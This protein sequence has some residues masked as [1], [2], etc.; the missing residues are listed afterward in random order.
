M[1]SDR[2]KWVH[3]SMK[4][5][6]YS[7][8]LNA[9]YYFAQNGDLYPFILCHLNGM[10]IDYDKAYNYAQQYGRENIIA[11]IYGLG[12]KKPPVRVKDEYTY[13]EIKR[14]YGPKIRLN[15]LPH[16]KD[17]LWIIK[18]D[19]DTEQSIYMK[20][21]QSELIDLFK[22]IHHSKWDYNYDKLDPSGSEFTVT[23]DED[24][25]WTFPDTQFVRDLSSGD[26]KPKPNLI[27]SSSIKPPDLK[28]RFGDHLKRD[29]IKRLVGAIGEET[30]PYGW[31]YITLYDPETDDDIDEGYFKY[32]DN[33]V[34]KLL[35]TTIKNNE[36]HGY[37]D[38]FEIV[39]NNDINFW[40]PRNP[41]I[42]SIL[43]SKG[44]TIKNID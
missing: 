24:T 39:T 42:E 5:Q 9:P 16:D 6:G 23:Y 37:I 1:D 15:D 35:D 40:S 4:Y 7:Y 29:E 25:Y 14:L 12:K 36:A 31:I 18:T 2:D 10:S 41:F 30:I 32:S 28:A 11:Y 13:E 21:A 22:T 34:S 19:R 27:K 43:K 26:L 8:D 3:A 44:V 33:L 20:Y 17:E 38:A